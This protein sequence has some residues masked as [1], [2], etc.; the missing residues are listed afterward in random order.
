[1]EK[2]DQMRPTSSVVEFVRLFSSS[3]LEHSRIY[4]ADAFL[5]NVDRHLGNF[6]FRSRS[7]GLLPLAFDF[8]QAWVN[9]LMPFG[10][11]PWSQNCKSKSA[12]K[13]L[14][15]NGY[16][17]KASAIQAGQALVSLPDNALQT[18]LDTCHESWTTG[19]NWTKTLDIWNQRVAHWSSAQNSLN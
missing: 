11:I 15:S 7:T 4:G 3:V 5:G 1:M 8:D 16:F 12:M 14:E 13:F 18:A 10:V 2:A 19:I 17:D 9:L 6:L